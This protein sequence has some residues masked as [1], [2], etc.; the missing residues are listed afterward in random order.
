MEVRKWID[1]LN[2]QTPVF[3]STGS[4]LNKQFSCDLLEE[5][6]VAMLG[7]NGSNDRTGKQLARKLMKKLN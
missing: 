7:V 5:L 2:L 6:K 1:D 4:M 3:V